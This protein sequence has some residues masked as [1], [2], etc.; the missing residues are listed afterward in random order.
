MMADN[1][2]QFVASATQQLRSSLLPDTEDAR[3]NRELVVGGMVRQ[4]EQSLMGA[5]AGIEVLIR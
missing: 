2:R 1:R 3:T 4:I 5:A